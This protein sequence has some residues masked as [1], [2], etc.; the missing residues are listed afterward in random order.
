MSHRQGGLLQLQPETQQ[1]HTQFY[2]AT[3]GKPLGLS[4][5]CWKCQDK[6]PS[7][8]DVERA[9]AY[10]YQLETYPNSTYLLNPWYNMQLMQ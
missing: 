7:E 3:R 9:F 10:T 2:P 5:A 1:Q 4:T 6:T 8:P